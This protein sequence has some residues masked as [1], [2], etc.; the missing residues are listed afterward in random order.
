MRR[1]VYPDN[2]VLR[3]LQLKPSEMHSCS[4]YRLSL[5][6]LPKRLGFFSW[7]LVSL[8]SVFFVK[9]VGATGFEPASTITPIYW[10]RYK[11]AGIRALTFDD[12]LSSP[13][14]IPHGE[15]QCHQALIWTQ[16]LNSSFL[17]ASIPLFAWSLDSNQDPSFSTMFCL[18]Y[19]QSVYLLF[20]FPTTS[21]TVFM[22][23]PAL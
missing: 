5:L 17:K 7:S 12:K 11:L 3:A 9:M 4:L 20:S 1:C 13:D 19:S 18:V 6:F 16:V 2:R 21:H 8:V 22:A 14:R 15:V 10:T 23:K